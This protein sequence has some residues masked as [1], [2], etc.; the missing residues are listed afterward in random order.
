MTQ[1]PMLRAEVYAH[2]IRASHNRKLEVRRKKEVQ[3]A[4]LSTLPKVEM[5][6]KY[7]WNRVHLDNSLIRSPIRPYTIHGE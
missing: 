7:I 3:C 1:I 5:F 6:M 4:V 2:A